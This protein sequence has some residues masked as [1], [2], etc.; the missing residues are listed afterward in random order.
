LDDL[1]IAGQFK[2]ECLNFFM[3]FSL[4]QLN[5]ISSTW[6]TYYNTLRPHRGVGMKNEVLD[7]TFRPQFDGAVRCTQQLGGIIKS[8]FREAA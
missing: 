4:G 5:R 7:E 8:Y 3:C 6:V 2:R 1:L